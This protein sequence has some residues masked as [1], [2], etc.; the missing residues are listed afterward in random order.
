MVIDVVRHKDTNTTLKP[1]SPPNPIIIPS[2]KPQITIHNS[3]F[4]KQ[5]HKT[6]TSDNSS[7]NGSAEYGTILERSFPWSIWYYSAVH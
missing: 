3:Q 7:T 1:Q 4:T 6:L 5:N 2:I